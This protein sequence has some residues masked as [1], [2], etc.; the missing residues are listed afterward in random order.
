MIVTCVL[1]TRDQAFHTIIGPCLDADLSPLDKCGGK[2]RPAIHPWAMAIIPI[3]CSTPSLNLL[4]HWLFLIFR[5]TH[6]DILRVM[7]RLSHCGGSGG[8]NPHDRSMS[9]SST[10]LQELTGSLPSKAGKQAE[11]CDNA[12]LQGV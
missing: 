8:T 5:E 4:M 11:G 9:G 6:I 10:D 7:L 12:W 3:S 1:I 2:T